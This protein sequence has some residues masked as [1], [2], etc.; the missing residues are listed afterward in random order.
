MLAPE[1]IYQNI[2]KILE[3]RGISDRQLLLDSGLKK[4]VMANM[5]SGSMPSADKIAIIAEYLDVPV[6]VLLGTKK[7]ASDISVRS[8]I[9]EK[10]YSL[11]DSQVDRLLAF[12]EGMVGE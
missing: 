11:S 8:S 5:K 6:D 9:I 4:N 12:L 7:A 1:Q 2:E 10:V 3:S